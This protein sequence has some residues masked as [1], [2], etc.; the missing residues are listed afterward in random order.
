MA[1]NKHIVIGQLGEDIALGYLKNR[2]FDVIERNYRKKWGEIDIICKKDSVLHFVEV[3]A[4]EVLYR[5]PKDGE[6]VYRPEDHM[7]VHKKKR[8]K[9][10]IETYVLDKG[11]HTT[12]NYTLDL[13]VVL[14]N[15]ET[16]KVKVKLIEDVLLD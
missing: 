10:I 1:K 13:I 3:K 7:H 9:R 12:K 8:L 16:K 14:I 5:F 4:G 11:M 6:E 2:G 15:T